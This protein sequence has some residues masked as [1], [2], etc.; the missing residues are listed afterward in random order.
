MAI[1]FFQ[2]LVCSC[3][4][5]G[6]Q[7]VVK[8]VSAGLPCLRPLSPEPGSSVRCG[9]SPVSTLCKRLKSLKASAAG[10]LVRHN[11]SE[12]CYHPLCWG[13]FTHL[14]L[15]LS[16]HVLVGSALQNWRCMDLSCCSQ[17]VSALL[18]RELS[19]MSSDCHSPLSAGASGP[20]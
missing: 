9:P 18:Q 10:D 13:P 8:W 14:L 19:S 15:V 20:I 5:L 1:F 3:Q 12:D 7:E 17:K 11:L 16:Y 2:L 4:G 6:T